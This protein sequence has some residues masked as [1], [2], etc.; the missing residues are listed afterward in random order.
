MLQK[1]ARIIGLPNYEENKKRIKVALI[2]RR[3][4]GRIFR[5]GFGLKIDKMSGV[6]YYATVRTYALCF[7]LLYAFQA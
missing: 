5:V 6:I 2:Q 3:K 7:R 4:P 1:K